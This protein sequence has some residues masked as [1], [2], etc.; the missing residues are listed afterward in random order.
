[1]K[2]KILQK[3]QLSKFVSEL[4]NKYAVY[5]P[6]KK[7][8]FYVFEKISDPEMIDLEY[9]NTK[10]PPKELFFPRAETLFT[11]TNLKEGIELT[12]DNASEENRVILGI[13][14]C[15]VLSFLLLDKFFNSGKFQDPYYQKRRENTLIIG[16]LCSEPQSTCFCTSTGGSPFSEAGM[17]ISLTDLDDKYLVK[18]LNI[19]GAQ[20][21]EQMPWLEIASEKDIFEATRRTKKALASIQN[22]IPI[23]KLSDKIEKLFNND[24]F[25]SQFSQK[26][27]NCGSC[28]FLCPTCHCFD[29]VDEKTSTGGKRIRLWD[30]CQFTLF[31]QHASGHNP[32]PS[33]K[34]RIR[35]RIMHKFCYYPKTLNEIACVGCGRCIRVCSVN[36]D[37]RSVFMAVQQAE[38]G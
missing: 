21:L 18:N 13:R 17:D 6:I 25:W 36:Q 5:T 14:P 30:T 19:K 4:M 1:M 29:V 38:G 26:C 32:R 2:E 34:E 35:Q 28:S 12:E 16:L 33:G 3:G 9:S 7:N 8:G 10:I 15:D 20:V 37:I 24:A 23:E 22:E 27:I 31:T 11:Y